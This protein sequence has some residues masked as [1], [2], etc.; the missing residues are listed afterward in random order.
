VPDVC[1]VAEY[2]NEFQRDEVN[3]FRECLYITQED[4]AEEVYG[5]DAYQFLKNEGIVLE[6]TL[7]FNAYN[8]Q[9][10][11]LTLNNAMKLHCNNL[12]TLW[13]S[14]AD[15][16][17]HIS[18]CYPEEFPRL[19]LDNLRDKLEKMSNK[20]DPIYQAGMAALA[21][22]ETIFKE[23]GK[24]RML[25]AASLVCAINVVKDPTNQPA[26][27]ALQEN[28]NSTIGSSKLSKF[29]RKLLALASAA[30]FVLSIAGIPFTGGLSLTGM[31]VAGIGGLAHVLFKPT[32][33]S[34]V[35][36][37]LGE[38]A[39]ERRTPNKKG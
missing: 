36:T 8:Q 28:A 6:N 31:P 26:I 38:A 34:K 4:S 11:T 18:K 24:K 2:K 22:G 35:L 7:F 30:I 23:E 21:E 1:P 5:K 13:A 29:R 39:E 3:R 37:N 32:S 25:L 17:Y 16:A 14:P 10:R 19:L 20:D 33:L 12:D 9:K 15:L 27:R